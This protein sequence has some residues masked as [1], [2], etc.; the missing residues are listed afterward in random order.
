MSAISTASEMLTRPKMTREKAIETVLY[1]ANTRNG[2]GRCAD[3]WTRV[4]SALGWVEQGDAI[5]TEEDGFSF[6]P[7]ILTQFGKI[8]L[9]SDCIQLI[10]ISRWFINSLGT[11]THLRSVCHER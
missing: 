11:G 6:S 2:K 10:L 7:E 5:A 3:Y 1:I 4:A 9:K 8:C